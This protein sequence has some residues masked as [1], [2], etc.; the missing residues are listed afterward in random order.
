MCASPKTMPTKIHRT[1]CTLDDDPRLIAGFSAIP[2]A[3]AAHAGLTGE[4]RET[5]TAAAIKSCQEAFAV[6]AREGRGGSG[7][8]FA[9]A[10]T[11]G[12]V[13]ATIEYAGPA[14]ASAQ[15]AA[16]QCSTG[17][18]A[19]AQY[20]TRDGRCRVTLAM[21]CPEAKAKARD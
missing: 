11:E 20:D 18:A 8:R 13:E 3:G 1:E 10:A 5:F 6:M 9:V 21:D 2:S 19:R 16:C 12:R 17:H 4:D 7:L 15:N 14:P